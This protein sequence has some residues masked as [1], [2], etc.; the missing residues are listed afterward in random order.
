MEFCLQVIHDYLGLADFGVGQW[1][2]IVISAA[3]KE[4]LG[5]QDASIVVR[6][7]P[8]KHFALLP[9]G[10]CVNQSSHHAQPREV[11]VTSIVAALTRTKWVGTLR[12]HGVVLI[13][14][15][16]DHVVANQLVD[17]LAKPGAFSSET[18][19]RRS[20]GN[21]LN[22]A[23]ATIKL[24]R[25]HGYPFSLCGIMSHLGDALKR[26][27]GADVG[28]K[29]LVLRYGAG[30]TNFAHQDQSTC[31]YQAVLLLSRPGVDFSGGEVY[32][33]DPARNGS[34]R[35]VA[36]ES[37]GDIVVFAANSKATGGANWHHGMC[38]VREGTGGANACQRLAV[39]LFH[40]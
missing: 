7:P 32:V 39:G 10:A 33:A 6:P 13:P 8:P 36:W 24:D 40:G 3:R 20:S 2:R 21:G 15:I 14:R 17:E 30:G 29:A 37:Q 16:I 5:A 1:Q 26:E 4:A 28:N 11:L 35:T 22:G 25:T 27:F 23:Y 18:T 9:V 31:P 34:R 19:L 12:E 38:E